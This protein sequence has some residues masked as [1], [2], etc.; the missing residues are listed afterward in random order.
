VRRAARKTVYAPPPGTIDF[1]DLRR[2]QPVS[3]V[4]GW[5]RGTLIDR[6]YLV[7]FLQAH[8]A[9]IKGHVLEFA[10]DDCTV[11]IGGKAVVKSDVLHMIEGNPK[12]TIVADIVTA[13]EE[14]IP[15]NQFDCIICTQVLQYVTELDRAIETLHRILKPGGVLLAT[16]P[17]INQLDDPDLAW[18][19]QW[20]LTGHMARRVFAQYFSDSAVTTYGNVLTA[21]CVLQGITVEELTTEE[22]DYH[23]PQY[24]VLVAVRAVK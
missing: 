12:A 1:G 6:Y 5:D 20:H 13:D 19:D 24:E 22:V 18:H 21:I 16:F 23:D 2:L 10:D 8:A 15:S 9:D 11:K 3:R 14:T 4:R 17:G 7:K